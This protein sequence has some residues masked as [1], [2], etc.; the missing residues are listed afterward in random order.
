MIA[1]EA[2]AITAAAE[3]LLLFDMLNSFYR[4]IWNPV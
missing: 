3:L 1:P 2:K 4:E